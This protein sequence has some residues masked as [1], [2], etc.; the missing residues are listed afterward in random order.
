MKELV[1]IPWLIDKSI[2]KGI[3][4]KELYK[5]KVFEV[6]GKIVVYDF[7]GYS[8]AFSLLS[9]FEG[10]KIKRIYFVGASAFLG[11]FKKGD[12]V[13]PSSSR[14]FLKYEDRLTEEIELSN[15]ELEFLNN[16]FSSKAGSLLTIDFAGYFPLEEVPV[17]RKEK[18]DFI[19]MEC[20]FIHMWSKRNS[21]KFYPI[22][23]LTD[24]WGERKVKID[25]NLKLSFSNAVLKIIG[26][27]L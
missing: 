4:K 21:L 1:L 10:E 27:L 5:S 22:L 6:N 7:L 19:D 11:D 20:G 18:F 3:P 23:I 9:E 2:F 17:L 8:H 14:I 12:I 26:N 15:D 24:E 16:N 25:E 13:I